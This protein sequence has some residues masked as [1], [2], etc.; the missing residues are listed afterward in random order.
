[1]W[2][3]AWCDVAVVVCPVGVDDAADPAAVF[4]FEYVAVVCVAVELN[5]YVVA[6]SECHVFEPIRLCDWLIGL[7][8][9]FVAVPD[10][11]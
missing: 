1:M 10:D 6:R 2:G 4:D 7:L 11:E 5:D 8:P 3:H 9:R